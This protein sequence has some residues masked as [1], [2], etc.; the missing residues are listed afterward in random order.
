M[1]KI[2][3]C[4]HELKYPYYVTKEGRVYSEFSQKFLTVSYDKD[5]YSK[6]R[7]SSKDLPNGK[8]HLYSVHRLVLENF[9]PVENMINLQVNH[10]DGDKT[11]NNITN[12]QWVTCK[13]NIHHAIEN[14]LRAKI[15][16]SAKLSESDVIEIIGRLLS[17]ESYSSI[18]KDFDVH[19]ETIARIKRKDS[20]TELTKNIIFN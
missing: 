20:W 9:N 1:K 17:K 16:G 5:G 4:K 18:C 3:N 12:L 19:K 11:N 7:M 10:I 8:Q 6:V 2:E 15:N 13:E 14:N